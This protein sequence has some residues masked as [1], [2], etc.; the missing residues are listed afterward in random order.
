MESTTFKKAIL[1]WF[2]KDIEVCKNRLQLLRKYNPDV[3]IYGLFGGDINEAKNYE[4]EL[5]SYL[6][7]FYTYIKNID[8]RYKWIHGDLMI[9]DWYENCGRN[10]NWDSLVIVQW[11]LLLFINIDIL[12][13]G[14]KKD[15]IFL[16]GL[17]NLDSSLEEKW[18]WTRRD[19]EY[20]KDYLD[21]LHYIE[22]EYGYK[23]SPSCCLFILQVF[24]RI[25][26]EQYLKVKNKELG[27]L[28]YKIPMYANIFNI[29]FYEKELGV[30]WHDND[31][32]PMNA[33]KDEI[34]TDYIKKEL[35]KK[36]GYRVFHPYFKLWS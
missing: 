36:D 35:D 17:R 20:R 23:E 19:K 33:K 16:S 15:E 18:H 4:K 22:K 27:F 14:I 13:N 8:E 28:E 32:Q 7:D 31:F 9:L 25:F 11:D 2:Y 10:L 29:P 12:F 6:D 26:F 1:F 21:F 34:N 30:K 5:E 3:E 24:P